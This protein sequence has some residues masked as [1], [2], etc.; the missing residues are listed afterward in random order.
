MTNYIKR[1][2][3]YKCIVEIIPKIIYTI[4]IGNHIK[5]TGI[6]FTN[7]IDAISK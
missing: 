3:N 6:D 2:N 1:T 7:G 4:Y 5:I